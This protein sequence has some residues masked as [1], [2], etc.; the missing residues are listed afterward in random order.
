MPRCCP[1]CGSERIG[2]WGRAHGLPRHRCR[3]CGR[4]FNALTGTPLARLRRRESWLGFGIALQ[5]GQSTSRSAATCGVARST[6]FRWRHRFLAAARPE[7]TLSGI[8]EADETFF[9]RSYKGARYW[10]PAS[11]EPPPREKPRKRGLSSRESGASL[12]ERVPILIMRDRAG[13]MAH[14]VLPGLTGPDFREAIEPHIARDALLCSDGARTFQFAARVIGLHHERLNTVAGE[15]VREVFHIQNVNAYD[16]R[17]KEWMQRFHGVSTRYL[18][19]YLTWRR[20]IERLGDD[21]NP[22]AF[23]LDAAR[24]GNASNTLRELSHFRASG[25]VS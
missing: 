3:D 25:Y 18:P 10:S 6:A 21:A 1:V 9:R 22:A 13:I 17:L 12:R 2:R 20:M 15:R 7:A 24:P 23:V 8:V 5:E 11:Q 16:S 14:A 19:N 4:T